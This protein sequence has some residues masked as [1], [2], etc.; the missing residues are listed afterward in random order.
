MTWKKKMSERAFSGDNNE[1]KKLRNFSR[2][3]RSIIETG[4]IFLTGCCSV[5]MNLLKFPE[6]DAQ[7]YLSKDQYT[8]MLNEFLPVL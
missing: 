1:E 7:T 6:F 5:P 3:S 2:Q 8:V 4:Q